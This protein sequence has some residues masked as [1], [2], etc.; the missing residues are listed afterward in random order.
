MQQDI[1]TPGAWDA[2]GAAYRR[3]I[4]AEASADGPS[5]CQETELSDGGAFA[6]G[7]TAATVIQF[8]LDHDETASI[9]DVAAW[10]RLKEEAVV[11]ALRYYVV[12]GDRLRAS[13]EVVRP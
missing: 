4:V 10:F 7:V 8:I 9:K 6:N 12:H 1:E 3:R 13:G 5:F 11:A 2:S